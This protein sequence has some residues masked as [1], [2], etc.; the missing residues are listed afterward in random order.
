[1]IE[2]TGECFTDAAQRVLNSKCENILL[3]HGMPTITGGNAISVGKYPHAWVEYPDLGMVH[4]VVADVSV[5]K[6]QYYD[7]GRI[8]KTY[9]YTRDKV[10]KLAYTIG[11]FGPW[12]K[13]LI[14]RDAEIDILIEASKE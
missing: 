1:M 6:K 3:V 9:V 12:D 14:D 2:R 8:S 4:D 10:L 7:V 13:E 11:T 5:P